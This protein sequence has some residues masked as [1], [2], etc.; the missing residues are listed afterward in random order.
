MTRASAAFSNSSAVVLPEPDA[1][2]RFQG[3]DIYKTFGS[4]RVLGGVSISVGRGEIV[5]LL[6]AMGSGKS[7][8]FKVLTGVERPDRGQVTLFGRDVTDLCIDARARLGIGY[9]PQSPE[10]FEQL[11]VEANLR[12]AIDTR[13]GPSE[14]EAD[15]I[16]VL[17]EGFGLNAMRDRRVSVL[18]RG[19]RRL[20]EI[21]YA[22][23]TLPKFLLLDEPFAGLDPLVVD[24]ITDLIRG[25][26]DIGIGILITDH[27]ARLILDLVQRAVVIDNG[28]VIADG[29]S[30][31]IARS[32]RVREVFLGNAN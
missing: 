8:L 12:M 32:S 19:Q 1:T 25:L 14:K 28:V 9:V 15:L 18:S 5:G 22:V 20:L 23:A 10:M 16:R 31:M 2:I 21:S 4:R 27:K 3:A 26:A 6:G 17:L 29:P 24:R 13:F 30:E 7:T 11:S